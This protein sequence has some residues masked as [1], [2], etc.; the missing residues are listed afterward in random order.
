MYVKNY[1]INV[2]LSASIILSLF[3]NYADFQAVIL[4]S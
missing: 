4:T 2:G 1:A 3:L